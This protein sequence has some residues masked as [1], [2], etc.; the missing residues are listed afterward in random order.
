VTARLPSRYEDLDPAFR[1]RLRPDRELIDI[2]QRAN[3]SMAVSGGIR[4]LPVY[5]RSGSGKSSAARELA[6]HLPGCKVV[7]LSRS[8]IASEAALVEEVRGA[9]SRRSVPDI[10]V[11][12]V[13]Q[14][15]ERVA[16]QTVLPEL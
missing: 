5:G 9:H 2:V 14:Y 4:F 8:A 13:D 12:V 3:G 15:E 7:E 16:E 1:A 10:V 11:A 6:T